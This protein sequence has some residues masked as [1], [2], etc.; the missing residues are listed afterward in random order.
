M[1]DQ[2]LCYTLQARVCVFN[3]EGQ[4]QSLVEKDSNFQSILVDVVRISRI[5]YSCKAKSF[6]QTAKPRSNRTRIHYTEWNE[7]MGEM[8][9]GILLICFNVL[10][11]G[12]VRKPF[13]LLML[14]VIHN[15]CNNTIQY[16]TILYCTIIQ[17]CI[18]TIQ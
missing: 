14:S 7:L 15:N 13:L 8:L 11:P 4:S 1:L 5:L 12:Y 6:H 3:Q 16:N 2:R 9:F 10:F 17:Y 18:I